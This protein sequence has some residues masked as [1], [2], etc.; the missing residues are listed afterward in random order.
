MLHD[1]P[2][3]FQSLLAELEDLGV[4]QVG[5]SDIQTRRSEI[6]QAILQLFAKDA[7]DEH[8]ERIPLV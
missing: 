8:Q 1:A 7:Q 5:N 2:L 6:L 3:R 4:S